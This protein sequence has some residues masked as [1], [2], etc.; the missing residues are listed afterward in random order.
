MNYREPKENCD[1]DIGSD[2]E[3]IRNAK[4]KHHIE[5]HVVGKNK[6]IGFVGELFSYTPLAVLRKTRT[7]NRISP[8]MISRCLLGSFRKIRR[9]VSVGRRR[10]YLTWR[11]Y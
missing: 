1:D 4:I 2:E 7:T 9:I 6:L 10:H 5:E 8:S 11:Q 3:A